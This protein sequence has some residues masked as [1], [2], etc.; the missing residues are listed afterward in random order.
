MRPLP[1]HAALALAALPPGACAPQPWAGGAPSLLLQATLG[2]T[3][4]AHDHQV[5]FSNPA[6]PPNIDEVKI[7][8]LGVAG[9]E[10][11]VIVHRH[12]GGVDVDVLRKQGE[13]EVLKSL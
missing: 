8:K 11:D 7:E 1:T 4:K 2:L 12:P 13:I 6:L 3:V 5:C 9:G 10:C